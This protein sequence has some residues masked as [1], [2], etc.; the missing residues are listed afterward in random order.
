MICGDEPDA[1]AAGLCLLLT[2]VKAAV[3]PPHTQ[4]RRNAPFVKRGGDKLDDNVFNELP[5][6]LA[7]PR[8]AELLG[9]SRAAAYRLAAT[10]E[11]PIR[12]LGGRVYVVT[13]GLRELM[14]S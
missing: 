8:A 3:V 6:L 4:R 9:I 2:V 11:L 10:G 14:A 13:A 12:R 1:G 5:L 7:V